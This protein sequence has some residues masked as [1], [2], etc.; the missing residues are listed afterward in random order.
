MASPRLR[1][2]G[3]TLFARS[4][5][6]RQGLTIGNK[7]FK[8]KGS[9]SYHQPMVLIIVAQQANITQPAPHVHRARTIGHQTIILED[10]G[11]RAFHLDEKKPFNRLVNECFSNRGPGRWN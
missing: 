7:P 6:H 4:N 3:L 5:P 8:I 11:R 10:A 9:V 1:R 2:S